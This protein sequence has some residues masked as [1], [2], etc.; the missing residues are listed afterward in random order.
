MPLAL[1][2]TRERRMAGRTSTRMLQLSDAPPDW[3]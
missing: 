2:T 3:W 1:T